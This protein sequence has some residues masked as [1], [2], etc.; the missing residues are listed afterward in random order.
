MDPI[1]HALAGGALG[2]L[3]GARLGNRAWLPGAIGGLAPD[4]DTLIRS[5]ADP[6][7]WVEYHRHF[8]HALAFIPVGGAVAALP[9]LLRRKGRADALP[10]LA[11]ATAGY[12]THGPLDAATTYGTLLF[13]PLSQA[14]VALSYIS[15]IDPVFTL[16]LVAGAAFALVYRAAW[17]A[18]A[19]LLACVL[20]I[21]AGGVQRERALDA[22]R[23]IAEARGQVPL[24][25][26]A[27]PTIA[28]NLVWR[29][30]Y[31][32]GDSLHSDRLRVPWRGQATWAPGP[33][34]PLLREEHL[35][36]AVAGDGRMRS[37]FQRFRW[38]S[39]GWLAASPTDPTLIGDARY[40]LA[41]GAYDP[42]WGIRFHPG[43]AP[44]T[45]W[46]DR[47]RTRRIDRGALRA[48]IAGRGAGYRPVPPPSGR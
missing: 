29:S 15:I 43:R 19:A 6:L 1:T 46:V 39:A 44:P 23:R 9:W 16:L 30:L 2:R 26:D 18:G 38:F 40:S 17:P 45:E 7:M 32:A 20:Y 11:A 14:R 5:G 4:L 22:Q 42:V 21:G 41:T 27:F 13:W 3:A 8:T 36:A 31:Q 12:A 37:D 10:A 48:E 35:P 24:R 28:N 25:G 34:M 47:S 33:S